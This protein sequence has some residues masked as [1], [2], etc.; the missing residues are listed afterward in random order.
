[1]ARRA[2]LLDTSYIVA[3][4]NRGDRH[5]E[6][7]KELDRQLLDEKC[8]S[9]LHWGVLM[10]I[11]D[12]YARADRRAKGCGLLDRLLNEDRYQ[13]L[14]VT[15]DLIQRA[16]N[17]YLGRPDKDWGLTDC[18]AFELMKAE[19]IQEALTADIH[20]RQAGFTALLLGSG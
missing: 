13:I 4:E 9:V 1:M 17:L 20:F 10:E 11:G 14:P 19:E 16:V 7:A 5:H 6:R 8:L 12:G 15:D 18:V 2:V 3:L